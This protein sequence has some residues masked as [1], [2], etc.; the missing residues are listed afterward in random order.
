MNLFWGAFGATFISV[1]FVGLIFRYFGQSTGILAGR[2]PAFGVAVGVLIGRQQ[3]F[4][5]LSHLERYGSLA[6]GLLI[7]LIFWFFWFKRA[8]AE[9][10]NG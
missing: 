1:A 5:D 8:S 10:T 4:N 7:L 6:G 3:I 9:I 2:S